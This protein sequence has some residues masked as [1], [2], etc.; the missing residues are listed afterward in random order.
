MKPFE[1]RLILVPT[2]L[3]EPAA[4]ALRYASSLGERLGARLLVIHADPF[5]SA[6]A[7][8]DLQKHAKQNVGRRVPFE[9]RVIA[10]EPLDAI[11]AQAR[12][13]GAD[14]VIMG[15]ADREPECEAVVAGTAAVT[16]IQPAL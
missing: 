15:G 8:E 11:V 7:Q 5:R 1:P 4:H 6:T 2:D 14:L 3:S 12:E 9:V 16:R 10:G 13:S